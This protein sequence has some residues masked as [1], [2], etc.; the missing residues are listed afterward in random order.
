MG[1]D[2]QGIGVYR[3]DQGLEQPK[4][5]V[6]APR[7]IVSMNPPSAWLRPPHCPLPFR[8]ARSLQL[9]HVHPS[10]LPVRPSS[11]AIGDMS[12][13]TS[14]PRQTLSQEGSVSE[15]PLASFRC[16]YWATVPCKNQTAFSL[17]KEPLWP[18]SIR[19]SAPRLRRHW[20]NS[21]TASNPHVYREFQK[22][23]T[24]QK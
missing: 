2:F 10:Q 1:E 21:N 7:F 4:K 3:S 12:Q 6:L 22:F 24:A 11:G 9:H 17:R 13:S 16:A 20:Q 18:K 23:K 5:V 14:E 8:P 15:S 19:P